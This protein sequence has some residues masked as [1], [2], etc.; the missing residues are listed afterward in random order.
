MAIHIEPVVPLSPKA[1]LEAARQHLI[2][3]IQETWEA[4]LTYESTEPT[5]VPGV[6]RALS[7]CGDARVKLDV[8]DVFTEG[9]R[10]TD[11]DMAGGGTR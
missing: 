1:A 6:R 9:R 7:A 2:E 11:E 4:L 3:A 10:L 5:S 8:A